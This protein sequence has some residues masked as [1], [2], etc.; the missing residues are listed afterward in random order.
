[1]LKTGL[2]RTKVSVPGILVSAP[3][4]KDLGLSR[5]TSEVGGSDEVDSKDMVPIVFVAESVV[6]ALWSAVA[7]FGCMC[8]ASE[9][10]FRC[11]L[12]CLVVLVLR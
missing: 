11:G 2:V 12:C 1:M 3:A 7:A 4:T 6:S 10:L 9:S 8:A 5:G